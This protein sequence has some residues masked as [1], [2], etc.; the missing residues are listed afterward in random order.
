[1]R[2]HPVQHRHDRRPRLD[3]NHGPAARIDDCGAPRA[4]YLML[5]GFRGS[6]AYVNVPNWS[7]NVFRMLE[8]GAI[9]GSGGITK[10]GAGQADLNGTNTY[11]GT[12]TV[13][14]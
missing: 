12:T 14:A 6:N 1:M 10:T 5:K 3:V 8:R 9:S 2:S 11:T 4:D 7:L 13:S